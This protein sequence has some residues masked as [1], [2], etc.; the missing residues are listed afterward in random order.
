MKIGFE[1][2]EGY[3][4]DAFIGAFAL[5][6]LHN[7]LTLIAL[8]FMFII[9]WRYNGSK[10]F[11]ARA[12]NFCVGLFAV[13][14]SIYLGAAMLAYI[15]SGAAGLA[16][17]ETTIDEFFRDLMVGALVI[18]FAYRG[19]HNSFISKEVVETPEKLQW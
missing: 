3:R 12:F 13:A 2:Y 19:F 4:K 6:T 11:I 8:P 9:E 15:D 5:V 1:S 7:L 10:T 18:I 17:F 16:K 14:V